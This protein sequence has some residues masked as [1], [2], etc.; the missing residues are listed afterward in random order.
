MEQG[1]KAILD[2]IFAYLLQVSVHIRTHARPVH[3]LFRVVSAMQQQAKIT[4]AVRT[5]SQ[6]V[7]LPTSDHV[8]MYDYSYC[9]A[10]YTH[11]H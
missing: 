5:K 10:L 7:L 11:L 2:L 8:F 4:W 1:P 9:L 3:A 6:A